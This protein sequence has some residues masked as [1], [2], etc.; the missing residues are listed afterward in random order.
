LNYAHAVLQSQLQ[1]EAAAEGY[2]PTIGIMHED[3]NGSAA[4]IFD[5]MEPFWPMVDRRILDF[6]KSHVFRP[7][8]FVVCSDGVC[9]L[10]PEMAR[11]VVQVVCNASM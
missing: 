9:R 6:V 10:S 1:I 11:C 7:A 8:D 2:D 5:L 3:N 4:F